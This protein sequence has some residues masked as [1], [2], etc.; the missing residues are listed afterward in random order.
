MKQPN[1]DEAPEGYEY[2]IEDRDKVMRSA[3][4]RL[5]DGRYYDEEGAYWPADQTDDLIIT[6]RPT[7]LRGPEDGLPPVGVT[8]GIGATTGIVVA[9][10]AGRAIVRVFPGFDDYVPATADQLRPIQTPEQIAAREREKAVKA[11][12][13][14][15][16]VPMVVAKRVYDKGYR[17]PDQR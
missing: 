8:V 14:D 4:H 16:D 6:K 15:L 1:W 17:K 7:Q 9:H 11:I 2:W 13:D 5:E 10:D 12:S 3:F